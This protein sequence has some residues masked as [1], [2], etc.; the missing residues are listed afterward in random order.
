MAWLFVPASAGWTSASSSCWA[1][2]IE[3][4]VTLSGKHTRR[5]SSWRGWKTRAWISLLSGT[6]LTPSTAQRGVD[7]WISSLRASRVNHGAPPDDGVPP[8][9]RGGLHHVLGSLAELGFDAEW[10]LFTAAEAGAPQRRER[11]FILAHNDGDGREGLRLGGVLDG[12]WQAQRD[13][14]DGRGILVAGA[15]GERLTAGHRG[16]RLG[17]LGAEETAPFDERRGSAVG[18][19]GVVGGGVGDAVGSGLE[20]RRREEHWPAPTARD[21]VSGA[22]HAESAEGSENLRT[23]ATLWPTPTAQDYGTNQGGAAGRVG[24]VRPSL[25]TLARSLPAQQTSKDGDASSPSVQTSRRRLNPDFVDWLMGLPIGWTACAPLATAL[26]RSRLRSPSASCG[27][28]S[29][30]RKE[31]T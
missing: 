20:E 28:D 22:G 5:R 7:S 8:L 16:T 14:A 18:R 11:L 10:S 24:P 27:T 13:D 29:V 31:A 12:R 19:S 6:T 15:H 2:D 26:C 25:S 17:E 9:V 1:T 30:G 23:A 21:G 3:L 4:S